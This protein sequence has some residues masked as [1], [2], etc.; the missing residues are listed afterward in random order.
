M[1]RFLFSTSKVAAPDAL[2]YWADEVLP[3]LE[4]ELVSADARD[5]SCIMVGRRTRGVAVAKGEISSYSGIWR[6][7]A[8]LIGSGDSLRICRVE[9]GLIRLTLAGGEE[10][11]VGPGGVFVLGPEA[12]LRYSIAPA[13]AG[14]KAFH[15]D[16][17]TVALSRLEEY[18]RRVPRNLAC[19]LPHTAAGGIV[20]TF[21]D[22]LRSEETSDSDFMALMNS[23]T[24][25]V[26]VA[27]GHC[28]TRLHAQ[29]RDAIYHRA[30]AYIRSRHT[31]AGLTVD[32]IARDL[33]VSE[34][35]LFAAFDNREV[36][37][38]RYIN[39]LRVETAKAMLVGKADRPS[40]MDISLNSGF[41]SVSTFNR[42]F[43]AQTGISP[44]DY[45]AR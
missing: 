27:L 11:E 23:F 7:N 18:G 42:Q 38:H 30:L 3:Q 22:A 19:P 31:S 14:G 9:S 2:P 4:V 34:R 45:R 1:E 10:H 44:S 15:I 12:V 41:D 33:G 13:P 28:C 26:A 16:M 24:E 6:E 5:F 21:V 29:A 40:I 17:T 20:N 25:V 35:A 37:P 43:R 36:T 32:G 8:R 39:R